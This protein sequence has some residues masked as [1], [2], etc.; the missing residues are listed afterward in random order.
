MLSL[1]EIAAAVKLSAPLET[2]I[3]AGAD[4]AYWQR[5][6]NRALAAETKSKRRHQA[7]RRTRPSTRRPSAAEGLARAQGYALAELVTRTNQQEQH[8]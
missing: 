6:V 4:L 8:R 2:V 7:S 1:S 3:P 5:L